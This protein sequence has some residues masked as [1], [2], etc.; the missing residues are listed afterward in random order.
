MV[1][2]PGVLCL[3]VV[4]LACLCLDLPVDIIKSYFRT[5]TSSSLQTFCDSTMVIPCFWT[6]LLSRSLPV[7]LVFVVMDSYRSLS[8]DVTLTRIEVHVG[9]PRHL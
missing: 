9:Y 3:M 5:L 7:F 2:T 1:Q 6:L 4:L 8:G